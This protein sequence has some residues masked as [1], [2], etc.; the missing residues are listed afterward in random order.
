MLIDY[1]Y[2]TFYNIE[3]ALIGHVYGLVRWGVYT[4][5]PIIAYIA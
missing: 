1:Y 5:D 2:G 3:D 4:M